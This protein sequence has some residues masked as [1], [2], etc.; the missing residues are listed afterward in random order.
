MRICVLRFMAGMTIVSTGMAQS[1]LKNGAFEDTTDGKPAGWTTGHP[2]YAKPKGSGLAKVELDTSVFQGPGHHSLRI[3]GAGNRGIAQQ[4]LQLR[5][6]WGTRF[7]LS[8]WMRLQDTKTTCGRIGVERIGEGGKWLG[9]GAALATDWR[10]STADWERFAKEFT[11]KPGTKELRVHCC[12]DRAN[13][14]IVWFDNVELEALDKMARPAKA[15]LAARTQPKT[16]AK[17]NEKG[18]V[19]AL[20]PIDD[21]ETE[22]SLWRGNAW[23][24][25]TRPLFELRTDGAKVGDGYLWV[26]CPSAKG[27]MVDRTWN[28]T[29]DWDALTFHVRRASGGGGMTLYLFCGQVVFG[30]KWFRPGSTWQKISIQASDFRY[31][32]GAKDDKEKVF[33]RHKVTKLSFGHEEVIAF[34]LDQVALD[35]KEGLVL[36]TARTTRRANLFAPGEKPELHVEVLNAGATPV[37]A[38]IEVEIIPWGAGSG[39]VT[40][41]PVTLPPRSYRTLAHR[42]SAV[43]LGYT[44][45]RV[46]LVHEGRV[47]GTH[48]V[49]LCGLPEPNR[50][51]RAFMGAS[52][53]GMGSSRADLGQ[54]LGVQ[55][56]ETMINWRTLE[57]KR[58]E[59]KLDGIGAALDAFDAHGFKT[60]CMLMVMPSR[61]PLWALPD[62]K[63]DRGGKTALSRDTEAFSQFIEKLVRRHG[64]RFA[65]YSFCCEINLLAHRLE[66]GLDGYVDLVKAGS[67]TIRR[68]QPNAIIGGIGVSGGDA[69]HTP[70]F[71]VARKLWERLHEHHDGFFFDTYASPRY[72]GT[73]LR[74]VEPEENDLAGILR[75]AVKLVRQYGPDKK[76]AIEEKGWAIDSRLPVDA[77]EAMAMARCLT[78]SY[79]LARSVDE[80]EHYMWFQLDSGRDEG[81]YSYS[82]FRHEGDALNPRPA[83]AAYAGVARLLAGA[84]QP[85]RIALHQD[86]YALTFAHGAGSHGALWTPLGTPVRLAAE[87]PEGVRVTNMFG[88]SIPV[89]GDALQLAK[90]PLF[91]WAPAV[92]RERLDTA[93]SKGRFQLP[94]AALELRLVRSD[95]VTVRVRSL[96]KADMDGE[97]VVDAPQ[98]WR[99]AKGRQRFRLSAGQIA[100]LQ[101]AV[102]G[103]K[104]LQTSSQPGTFRAQWAT[105]AHGA[106]R[107]A[108]APTVF[109]VKRLTSTPIIDGNLGEFAGLPAIALDGQKFL[110]PPDAPSAKLWT[111]I[112]DLSATLHAAWDDECFYFAARVRDDTFVQE[113]TGSSIWANDSFQLALDPDNDTPGAAFAGKTGYDDDDK[114]F[115]IALTTRGPQIFQWT[116]APDGVGRLVARARLAVRREGDLTLYE[117]AVPWDLIQGSPAAKGAVLRFN[118]VVLDVDQKGKTARY[119][120]GLTPGICGGKDPS[121]F[122]SFLLQ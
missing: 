1:V 23:G 69:R 112:D 44:S 30:G 121:A 17:A 107:S 75:D 96:L 100:A 50:D 108:M 102:E 42:L 15:K 80:V 4:P 70:R 122:H 54:K 89:D 109:L 57:P 10:K 116:G 21:F 84:T 3:T 32:W 49:G 71:P 76:V 74:V 73:G 18:E 79:L 94:C 33:D 106:V 120:M 110:E 68:L 29:G 36:R 38:T 93:L 47:A 101:F 95:A 86:L 55:A 34:D 87:L 77:P 114:E 88:T 51:P 61:T 119:W 7:R 103:S 8:G 19:E 66:R 2:W 28:Y 39:P 35:L 5:P 52:G 62:R 12:T 37:S 11:V 83:A 53:F 56:A 92:A 43:P 25:A 45:A 63:R 22:D 118:A 13:H 27:N 91:L 97:L 111:G 40:R 113:R 117:W 104:T 81:G 41:R 24:G 65:A 14:G 20:I 67:E 9:I 6:E 60:T 16:P 82:L 78:R 98:G 72:Y 31:S 115:G 26:T 59:V 64:S 99:V 90:E 48:S 58:G 85:R 105:E 46:R